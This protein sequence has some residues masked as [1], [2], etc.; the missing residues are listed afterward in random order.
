MATPGRD[1]TRSPPLS[2]V[3]LDAKDA[4]GYTSRTPSL[5]GLEDA[6]PKETPA[7][8]ESSETANEFK[9]TWRFYAI[10]ITLSIITLA[11]ALDATSKSTLPE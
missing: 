9:P 6:A 4:S 1:E 5:A 10:F 3:D 11:A 8:L 2:A 7:D